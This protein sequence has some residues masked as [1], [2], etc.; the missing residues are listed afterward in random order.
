[1]EVIPIYFRRRYKQNVLVF[2]KIKAHF[3]FKVWEKIVAELFSNLI[4]L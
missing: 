1:M 4:S 3:A 2:Y